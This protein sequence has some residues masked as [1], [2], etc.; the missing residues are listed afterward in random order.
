MKQRSD[1]HLVISKCFTI[2]M[3][4]QK[5]RVENPILEKIVRTQENQQKTHSAL[6]CNELHCKHLFLQWNLVLYPIMP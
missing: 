1:T 5:L 6:K 3:Y 4:N 2:T